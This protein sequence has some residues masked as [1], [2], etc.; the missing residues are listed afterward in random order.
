MRVF[1][2]TSGFTKHDVAYAQSIE[3]MVLIDDNR[4]VHLMMDNEVGTSVT[5]MKVSKLDS[6]YFDW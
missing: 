5:L 2:T 1:I 3:G 6:D 4:L